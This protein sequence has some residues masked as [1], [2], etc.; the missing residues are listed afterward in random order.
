[1][2]FGILREI[3]VLVVLTVVEKAL[4]VHRAIRCLFELCIDYFLAHLVIAFVADIQ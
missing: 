3:S 1:M 2:A 4:C